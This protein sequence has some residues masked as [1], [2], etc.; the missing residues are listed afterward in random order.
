MVKKTSIINILFYLCFFFLELES[1][2]VCKNTSV[3]AFGNNIQKLNLWNQFLKNKKNRNS[4]E[5]LNQFKEKYGI[6]ISSSP[7]KIQKGYSDNIVSYDHPCGEHY[8]SFEKIL[9]AN[10]WRVFDIVYEI[11]KNGNTIHTW[12]IPMEADILTISESSLIIEYYGNI[13]NQYSDIKYYIS[14]DTKGHFLFIH[15]ILN[16]ESIFKKDVDCKNT[17]AHSTSDYRSCIEMKD[18]KTKKPRIIVYENP[19]T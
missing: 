18:L 15:P 16:S 17:K 14:I 9:R 2:E 1:K 3:E 4:P 11:D 13:C 7:G 6:P 12:E 19:C 10:Q 5:K 8:L